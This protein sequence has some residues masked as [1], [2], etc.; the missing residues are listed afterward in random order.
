[1]IMANGM[2]G[3]ILGM[4]PLVLNLLGLMPSSTFGEYRNLIV[5]A[6]IVATFYG[7]FMRKSLGNPFFSNFITGLG[8]SLT[9]MGI[10]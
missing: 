4:S 10:N 6:G 2:Q 1:M 5:I 7:V 3:F 9:F 8:M